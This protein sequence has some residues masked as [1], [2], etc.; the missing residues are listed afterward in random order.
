MVTNDA[1]CNA[2]NVTRLTSK[3]SP[4]ILELFTFS[5]K[6]AL[7]HDYVTNFEKF[8][9]RLF[10]LIYDKIQKQSCSSLHAVKKT[11]QS[12]KFVKKVLRNEMLTLILKNKKS[13]P[14]EPKIAGT[15]PEPNFFGSRWNRNQSRYFLNRNAFRDNP[16]YYG[17]TDNKSLF[18]RLLATLLIN[19]RSQPL[20]S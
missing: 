19:I 9:I 20:P 4:S 18:F 15:E 10:F 17:N 2:W 5:F 14:T 11:N 6:N 3:L 8:S 7:L 1:T 12:E 16:V 13:E